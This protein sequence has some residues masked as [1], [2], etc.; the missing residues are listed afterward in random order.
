VWSLSRIL[1]GF[2]L[3]ISPGTFLLYLLWLHRFVR[4]LN[5]WGVDVGATPG[6]AVGYW[7]VPVVNLIMP[8]R[9]IRNILVKLGGPSFA[10]SFHVQVCWGAF[11]LSRLLDR[12][13]RHLSLGPR[14]TP[15]PPLRVTFVLAAASCLCTIA[16]ALLCARI[17]RS[18]Q[19]WIDARRNG[20]E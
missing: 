12:I 5:A 20:L 7:F 2:S 17:V 19:E 9:I 13:A 3:F 4:Q 10:A 16:A 6:W 1:T 15:L 14:N 8:L 11:L 18:A